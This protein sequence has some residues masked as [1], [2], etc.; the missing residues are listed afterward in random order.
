MTPTQKLQQIKNW[1]FGFEQN[2]AF[3]R[4]KGEDDTEYEVDGE[5]SMGKELYSV[6]ADG[7]TKLAEDGDYTISGKVLNVVRG[8]I[9]EVISGNRTIEPEK[10][11]E[12]NKKESMSENVKMV[13]DA[14]V[15]GTEVSISG[16]EIVAGADLRIV[17]DGEML[18]PPA[19]EHRLKSGVVVVVDDAGKI[20]EVKAA[21]EEPSVEIEV[22]AAKDKSME[23][24]KDTGVK[25][26]E[27]VLKQVMEAVAEMKEA[28]GEMKKKQEKMKEDFASFKKEPAAEPLKR[29]SVSNSYQFGSGENPRVQMIEALKGQLK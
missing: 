25:G 6:N 24:V 20:T 17:K 26:V 27:E 19:G 3:A 2:H 13:S 7:T 23:D 8:I 5:I 22:E 29:N 9:Q 1:L 18:L 10:I 11:N 15:D 4:Y 14:L 21:E 12:E 16:D 28:M